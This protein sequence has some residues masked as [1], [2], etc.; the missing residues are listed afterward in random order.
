MRLEEIPKPRARRGQVVVAVD[1]VG[2]NAVD[3]SNRADPAWAGIEPPY[4]VGYEFAGRIDHVGDRVAGFATGQP[5]WG[6]LPVRGTRWG[7]Y[8]E[9]VAVDARLVAERPR[10]L[11]AVEAAAIPLAGA[12]ALQLLDRLE[13]DVGDWLLV[14]GAAGGVGSLLVQLA[15]AR[16]ANVAG[17]ASK[18]RHRLLRELGVEVV[19]DREDDDVMARAVEKIGAEPN[20]VADLVGHG[21]LARSLLLHQ[22]RGQGRNDR[23]ADRR[24]RRGDR[25]QRHAPRRSRQAATRNARPAR[26]GGRS[27]SVAAGRRRGARLPCGRDRPPP[28]RN[29]ARPGEGHPAH[30]ALSRRQ[31]WE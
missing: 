21:L 14:L 10:T 30:R 24:P 11:D 23:R 12:T 3:A 1:A 18:A 9:F 13:P 27:R 8:A 31:R 28:G 6:V 26:R 5:V 16:G 22:G 2:V 20:A 7:T 29:R 17:S 4:V 19:L 15:R 25:S